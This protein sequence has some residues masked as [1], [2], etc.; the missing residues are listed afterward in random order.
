MQ[1]MSEGLVIRNFAAANEALKSYDRRLSEMQDKIAAMENLIAQQTIT[2]SG[3]QQHIGM[4]IGRLG[5][6]SVT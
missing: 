1:K 3:M 6:G 2:I 4:L 5:N